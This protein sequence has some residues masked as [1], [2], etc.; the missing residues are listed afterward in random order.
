MLLAEK[1]AARGSLLVQLK[2][3]AAS[4]AERVGEFLQVHLNA[5]LTRDDWARAIGPTRG[6]QKANKLQ[7]ATPL[8][9]H[10]LELDS[11][12]VREGEEIT[13]EVFD[14]LRSLATFVAGRIR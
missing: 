1:R 6:A 4:E 13:A 8:F 7:S 14:P 3:I 11:M 5:R 2:P 10:L 9:S 12:G